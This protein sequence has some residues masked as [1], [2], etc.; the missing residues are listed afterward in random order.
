MMQADKNHPIT[1]LQIMT[2]TLI[3]R[4]TPDN[5]KDGKERP[6]SGNN[7]DDGIITMII[8]VTEMTMKNSKTI[9]KM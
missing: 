8:T 6:T 5:S 9:M 7:D 2:T 1:T 3:Q 4:M